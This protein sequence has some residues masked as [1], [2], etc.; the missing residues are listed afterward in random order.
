M[1]YL[2]YYCLFVFIILLFAY[3]NSYSF[4]TS[5]KEPFTSKLREVYRPIIRKT[6]LYTEGF[7]DK[8]KK[9]IDELF[10]KFG[11]A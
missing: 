11:I 7:Y 9:N 3:I 8:T 4:V 6:R 1:K 2:Y 5:K 10:Y